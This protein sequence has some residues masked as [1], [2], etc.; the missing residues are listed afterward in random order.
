MTLEN[1]WQEFLK[2]ISGEVGSRVVETW[3]KA[4]HFKSCDIIQKEAILEAPNAFVRD[5]IE[6][7][8]LALCQ[9]H[10]GRL[11]NVTGIRVR[12]GNARGVQSFTHETATTPQDAISVMPA[13]IDHGDYEETNTGRHAGMVKKA[14]TNFSI[15]PY[16]SFDTI[17][18]GPHNA[19]ACAAA[20]AVSEQPGKLYNPLFIYGASGLGK[21]H[22]LHAIGNGIATKKR[23][24]VVVYQTAARFVTE[25]IYAIRNNKTTVFEEKY[26]AV[27][28]LL[29]DDLQFISHKEQ[30]QEAFFHIFNTLYDARK[31]MVFSSDA[32]PHDME[33]IADRLR[34]RLSAGLITDLH[35]PSVETKI[36]IVKKKA[37][38]NHC[39]ISDDVAYLIASYVPASIRELEGALMR[40]MALSSLTK[41]SIDGE[42]V[43]TVLMRPD[44]LVKARLVD[45]EQVFKAVPRYYPYDKDA[46]CSTVRSKELALAR[47]VAMYLMKQ[48]TGKSFRD[49][50]IILGHRDHT[51]VMHAVEK[52]K[53]RLSVDHEFMLMVNRIEQDILGH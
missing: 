18:V 40:V 34:S 11:L 49:I 39:D 10:L 5:W 17:V 41:Q 45:P 44:Q 47:H 27:D 15:N 37:K 33:G 12:I 22:L 48:L 2:I 1:T 26:Q 53:A 6:K 43:K 21:T 25:F 4:V 38:L 30:T 42:L 16:Y 7:N 35:A 24:P 28:L 51:T 19:L 23:A 31:Q 36:E 52:V 50:G 9:M 46:L 3:F 20:R 13:I 32:F 14:N 8:Y 29:V